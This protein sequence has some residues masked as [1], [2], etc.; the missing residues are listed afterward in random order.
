MEEW[1]KKLAAQLLG[2]VKSLSKKTIITIIAGTLGLIVVIAIVVTIMNTVNYSLLY[3]GLDV[4]EA[5]QITG[6]LT[7]LGVP[8]KMQGT[9]TIY[10]DSTQVDSAKMKLAEQGYPKSTLAYDTF[11]KGTNWAMTDSDKK[12]LALYQTQDRLQDTIKTIS[13]VT[14]AEV[15]I[16]LQDQ[17]SYV[18]SS[19]SVP[20]TAS[21]KLNLQIGA[22][23]TQK[24]VNGIVLLVSRAVPGLA[25]ANI[26]VL[27]SDGSP[28]T[29]DN[30]DAGTNSSDTKVELENEISSQVRTKVLSVLQSL[31]GAGK[32]KVAAGVVLDFSQTLT[33][34][35]TTYS[36][37]SATTS[38]ASTS[39]AGTSS[40]S[41]ALST[42]SMAGT[43]SSSATSSAVSAPQTSM[44]DTIN[45]QIQDNGGKVSKLTIAVV[46]DSKSAATTDVNALKNTVAFATGID[47]TGVN[48]QLAPFATPAIVKA[49]ATTTLFSTQN[50]MI[51]AATSLV[52]ILLIAFLIFILTRGK[53]KEKAKARDIVE[54]AA[55]EKQK[56]NVPKRALD[57]PVELD[58]RSIEEIINDPSATNT[59]KQIESFAEKKPELVAQL[60]RN[61]LKDS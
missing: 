55:F 35:T 47:A 28:L 34:K 29:D 9:G 31:Y 18:L 46:I 26:T 8:Y 23:L 22:D 44:V 13:G 57:I 58:E 37:S 61:W 32:V 15:N 3:S 49:I 51:I 39:S 2:F 45:Q 16:A 53:R 20:T 10:V 17:S 40:T 42:S 60:L 36:T 1:A 11:M 25:S 12:M 56:I 38:S 14:S 27:D 43:T 4:T 24:Q 59:R 30:K 48:V 52:A 33:N 7:T 41:S 5:G 21:V 54:Q 6:E 19:D 50:I